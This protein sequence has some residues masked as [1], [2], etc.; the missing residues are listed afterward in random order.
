LRTAWQALADDRPWSDKDRAD[1]TAELQAQFEAQQEAEQALAQADAFL[2][3][4]AMAQEL[5]ELR[6]ERALLVVE[7]DRL[8]RYCQAALAIKNAYGDRQKK[9][10]KQQMADFVRVISALFL[11]MQS[12][13]VYDDVA[14]GDDATP[15][16]WRALAEDLSL[17][18]EATFSQG[19]RQD[20]ALSI[21]LARARGLGGTFVLDEPVAHLDDLNR[22]ALLDVFRA[23]TLERRA[24]LS[25]VM[26][27]ANKPLVRHLLE[28]F[29]RVSVSDSPAAGTLL[30]LVGIEGNPRTGVRAVQG[31]DLIATL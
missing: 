10:V 28:K 17:N 26:T 12:N 6:K 14:S 9:H 27:T 18:P 1:V 25:F 20:F 16:S 2:R 21:F 7:R 13:L 24:D 29:A 3:N 15:L 31:S 5:E 22:V 23:I 4:Q 11:R 8:D 19:Q 30:N